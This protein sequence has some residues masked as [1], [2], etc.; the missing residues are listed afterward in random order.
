MFTVYS[1]VY[2]CNLY[3]GIHVV[4]RYLP[5]YRWWDILRKWYPNCSLLRYTSLVDGRTFSFSLIFNLPGIVEGGG[6]VDDL[7]H[8][9]NVVTQ[10]V[11]IIKNFRVCKVLYLNENW[12]AS[13]K[14]NWII[15]LRFE[16][17]LIQVWFHIMRYR[18]RIEHY[19]V[20]CSGF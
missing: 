3:C 15:R 5:F 19:T 14:R 2:V 7:C 20:Y 16:L 17:I 6:S 4:S 11:W 12:I 1:G 13:G 8:W 18:T 10:Y 9:K